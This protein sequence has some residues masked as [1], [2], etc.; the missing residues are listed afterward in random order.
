MAPID[1]LLPGRCHDRLTRLGS[2]PTRASQC[3][4]VPAGNLTRGQRTKGGEKKVQ[5]AGLVAL[6]KMEISAVCAG[7]DG[8]EEYG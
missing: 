2:T 4:F 1:F 8:D 3:H 7:G 6:G 5:S